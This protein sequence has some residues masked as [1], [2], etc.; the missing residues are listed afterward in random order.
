[1]AT[2]EQNPEALPQR[3]RRVKPLPTDHLTMHPAYKAF[4]ELP[5]T[6]E[7]EALASDMQSN[8]RLP[9]HVEAG[10]DG[11]VLYGWHVVQAARVAGRA[12]MEVTVRQDLDGL[13]EYAVELE[14]IDTHLRHGQL[15][16]ITT[17]RCLA[18]AHELA[19]FV[20]ED[21]RR[22]YQNGELS[23]VVAKH[24]GVHKRSA[25]RYVAVT[26]MPRWFQNAFDR[27]EVNIALAEKVK[28]LSAEAK[29]AV[30][31]AVEGGVSVRKAVAAHLPKK[32]KPFTP[33]AKDLERFVRRARHAVDA[34]TPRVREVKSI[35]AAH[36]A[37]LRE[38][39][40]VIEVML[41]K[42]SGSSPA[43]PVAVDPSS[44]PALFGCVTGDR[45]P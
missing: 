4:F 27:G 21:R 7:V 36:E 12:E 6:A 23:A 40:A 45:N 30:R 17:A 14:M 32:R 19:D 41:G 44:D 15:S 34:L 38:M 11:T 42:A 13:N 8:P 1:M 16:P 39:K 37:A 5:P 18:R 33:P 24:L 26:E 10:P 20:P 28:A 35:G 29:K 25:D 2:T 22:S 3:T 43:A 31:E 9:C